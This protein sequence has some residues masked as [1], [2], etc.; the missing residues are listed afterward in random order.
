[1]TYNSVNIEIRRSWD[2]DRARNSLVRKSSD[3]L[4]E[5]RFFSV[6]PPTNVT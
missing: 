4:K 5:L 1:V 2:Y 6:E 3:Q